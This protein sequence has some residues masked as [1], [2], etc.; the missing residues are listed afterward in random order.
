[1]QFTFSTILFIVKK[2]SSKGE[3]TEIT[4]ITIIKITFIYLKNIFYFFKNFVCYTIYSSNG[5]LT[6]LTLFV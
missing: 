5:E 3:L 2:Y 1:M 6:E 4:Q